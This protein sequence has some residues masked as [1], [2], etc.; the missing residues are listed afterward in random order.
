MASL[1]AHVIPG[2]IIA[3]YGLCWCINS[4]WLYLQT[5]PQDST[6][7]KTKNAG[8]N[9]PQHYEKRALERKSWIP[10][11]CMSRL[12]IESVGKIVIASIG[13]TEEVFLGID[14]KRHLMLMFYRPILANGDMNSQAKFFHITMYSFFVLSGF[15]DLLSLCLKLP[16]YTSI[17]VFSAAFY[18]ECLL[19]YFHIIGTGSL[20]STTHTLLVVSVAGSVVFSLLRLYSPVNLMINL[21]LSSTI[22]LQGTWLIQVGYFVFGGYHP[23]GEAPE[24]RFMMF[25]I[26]VYSWH[27]MGIVMFNLMLLGLLTVLANKMNSW[28]LCG[29]SRRCNSLPEEGHRLIDVGQDRRSEDFEV[30]F[31][32]LKDNLA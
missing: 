25:T 31:K 10:T 14:E 27:I 3:F 29:R 1:V 20:E 9:Y 15:V 16:K 13:I 12:P 22:L 26:A 8:R 32:E 23:H 24:F 21:G 19:F 5:T 18:S 17:V 28:K 2:L 30:D 11:T 4:M 7:S 6:G